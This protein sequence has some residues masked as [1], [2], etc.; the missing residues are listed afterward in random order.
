MNIK[1]HAQLQSSKTPAHA[2]GV[3]EV[4]GVT[5]C[6]VNLEHPEFLQR[7]LT[8]GMDNSALQLQGELSASAIGT[9]NIPRPILTHLN[10]DT[11][12]LLQLPW[13]DA[14]SGRSRFNILIDPWFNG[15][16]I[17]IAWW[18]SRQWHVTEP[19]VQSIA[20][21]NERLKGTESLP[22]GLSPGS[23]DE[24]SAS[25]QQNTNPYID[26]VLISHEFT[27]HCNKGTLLEID[28]ATPILANGTAAVTI[29]SWSHF[30]SVQ[31]IPALS[32]AAPM[33]RTFT[34]DALPS[35]LGVFR[36]SQSLDISNT[37]AAVVVCFNL[38]QDGFFGSVT[39]EDRP[40]EAVIYT[41]HG[42]LPENIK[43]LSS[44]LPPI[45][46]L[47]LMHGLREVFIGWFG[48]VNLG[49]VNGLECCENSKA[50]YWVPTHDEVKLGKGLIKYLLRYNSLTVEEAIK[51]LKETKVKQRA[52]AVEE[53]KCT[54]NFQFVELN[55]GDS[56]LLL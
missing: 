32:M 13:K 54:E 2:S 8:I 55:S 23:R 6:C 52:H 56:L 19:A 7:C 21:L 31:D 45:R 29:R 44:A 26:A 41:P 20:E 22:Q 11:S 1:S 17:D 35:W 25:T 51:R 47:V 33:W 12:W 24:G 40:A 10:G 18:F 46:P 34:A 38:E 4:P 28:P 42:L 50:R 30:I 27:D 16:Q 9:C 49:A 36:I 43:L 15:I 5:C 53:T 39:S 48:R 37:H 3:G 14:P